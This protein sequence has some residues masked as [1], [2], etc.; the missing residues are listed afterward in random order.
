MRDTRLQE[1]FDRYLQR[2]CGPEE[3]AELVVLLE[4]A[5]AVEALSEPMFRLWE[6]LKA[7]RVEYPVDWER[8][9]A[10][11]SQVGDDPIFQPRKR[12]WLMRVAVAASVVVV[13]TGVVLW[14]MNRGNVR[15][16]AVV[17]LPGAVAAAD[18]GGVSKTM[19]AG[20]TKRVVHLPDGSTVLLNKHSRLDYPRVFR[21]SLREVVL[22]GEA[23]FDISHLAGRPFIVHTGKLSTRV[24]GTAFNIRDYPG[25]KA[26]AITV[27]SGKV[28]VSNERAAVGLLIANQQMRYD[29]ASAAIVQE[30][31]DVR[32]LV[33]WRPAEI[34]FDDI[35]MGEAARRVGEWLG[36]T[37]HFV[38]PALKNCRVT[39][40]F[41][42]EDQLEEILMVLCGVNE[43]SYT[44]HDKDVTIDGRACN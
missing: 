2:R 42:R 19:V 18:A 27:T 38:D 3:V 13:V 1:L 25:D 26:I 34:S 28:Q 9:Y 20:D 16:A 6:E 39:A 23:Y 10:R 4:R 15:K 40:S 36:V 44:I 24:L 14:G 41:Y 8:M 7:S 17:A 21:D 5:D 30:E 22:S 43:M 35:T 32:P 31:V 29:I 11:V 33:A 37:I 12:G